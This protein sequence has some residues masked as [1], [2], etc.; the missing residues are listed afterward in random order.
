MGAYGTLLTPL[1]LALALIE[2]TQ[3]A[4][5]G[6][7]GMPAFGTSLGCADAPYIY[8]GSEVTLMVPIGENGASSA[9]D[10][11]G[12]SVGTILIADG[13]ADATEIKYTM[14]LRTTKEALLQQVL[15]TEPEKSSDGTV[16]RSRLIIDTPHMSDK[17]A[18]ECMRYDVTV[19]LPPKLERIHVQA[20]TLAHV[21]F[22]PGTTAAHLQQLLV[23]LYALDARNILVLSESVVAKMQQFD[24]YRGYIVGESSIA[25]ELSIE[26]QRGDA[27]ANVKIRP[28][29]P[30][31][32]E[33]PEPAILRTVSGGGRSD[34]A[35]LGSKAFTRSIS[36]LHSASKNADTYLTYRGA[37]VNGK[38][39][40]RSKSYTLTGAQSLK[41]KASE[42][43]EEWT[44][45]V[46]NK[47]G[48]DEIRVDSR[49]WTGLYF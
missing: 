24:A 40:L 43:E 15:V 49:G 3:D 37:D 35:Y 6:L 4:P 18:G 34:F 9:V 7:E 26:T 23:T 1:S 28:A 20:R 38:I 17:N 13:P 27:V 36:A 31:D 16:L 25:E 29:P 5:T 2:L 32:P 12:G 44:H 33:H 42:G 30:A 22:A 8:K 11:R 47:D 48:G 45:Y 19:F 39:Q 41:G 46:G 21:S 14:T 10:M